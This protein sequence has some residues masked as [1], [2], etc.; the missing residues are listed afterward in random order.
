[1]INRGGVSVVYISSTVV[2]L[3]QLCVGR[4]YSSQTPNMIDHHYSSL[5]VQRTYIVMNIQAADRLRLFGGV[6][7]LQND[8]LFFFLQEPYM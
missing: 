3:L 6:L 4:Y 7:Q 2:L 1:M 8:R 5:R